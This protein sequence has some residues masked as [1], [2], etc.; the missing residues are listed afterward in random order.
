MAA[1]ARRRDPELL[2]ARAWRMSMRP[3]PLHRDHGKAFSGL[4]LLGFRRA[5]GLARGGTTQRREGRRRRAR[6]FAQAKA[7]PTR[8][9]TRSHLLLRLPSRQG[10][11]ERALRHP[12]RRSRPTGPSCWS[13]L[14]E[15]PCR[16]TSTRRPPVLRGVDDDL[17]RARHLRER[18]P[19]ARRAG[20][21]ARLAD[22]RAP[23]ILEIPRA[24]RHPSPDPRARR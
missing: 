8:R 2:G 6:D 24:V 10:P 7:P 16:D 21:E 12:P 9:R 18:H 19:R 14:R 5:L 11:P 23:A 15:R 1:H 3:R 13:A 4:P 22:S 20:G 17:L